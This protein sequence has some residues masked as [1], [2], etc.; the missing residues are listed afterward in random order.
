M[1]ADLDL[2]LITKRKRMMDSVGHYSRPE[3]LRLLVDRTPAA[4]AS[5][6][7]R[8]SGAVV[9]LSSV[10]A[11][12]TGALLG[13]S[14]GDGRRHRGAARGRARAARR[15]RPVGPSRAVAGRDDRDGADARRRALALPAARPRGRDGCDDGAGARARCCCATMSPLA[16]VAL[17][18]T[19]RFYALATAD[20]VPYPKIAL[21]HARNVLAST[22]M[23][24]CV[25]Y[26][27]PADACKFCA[28]GS[29]L[30]EGRTLARKSPEQL[31]E[32]AE[33][34]VRLDGVEQLVMTTGTPATPDRGAAHLA[35]CAAAVRAAVPSLPIQVQCEPPD[36][37]AWFARLAAAGADTLGMH[38]E[39]V[40][41]EVRARGDAR[42]GAGVGRLLPARLRGRR[43]GV[44]P[45]AGEH[46]PHR[47][48]GRPRPTRW[49]RWP[50]RC[51]RWA[52]IRSWSRS[53]PSRGRRLR[54]G[55]AR[56]RR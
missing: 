27:D 16:E 4:V 36:D 24:S 52:C 39:A 40:E 6:P 7:R 46:V 15:R 21:L 32:V 37:F 55:R 20:G 41:P 5:E 49:W 45:R 10:D 50:R 2:S 33:A 44:R 22:V 12:M 31:A 14:A 3:L 48:A 18:A 53:R 9:G 11:R 17:P 47:G 19:P 23:Q 51:W 1:Y 35:A 42:Q 54:T 13:G 28:I 56:R 25:R 26:N 30:K 34:A 43:R 8:A 29:S 38:L